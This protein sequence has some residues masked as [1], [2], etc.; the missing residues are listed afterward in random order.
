MEISSDPTYEHQI[1]NLSTY[2]DTC[3]RVCRIMYP[4]HV[5]QNNIGF[6]SFGWPKCYVM[7]MF[8]KMCGENLDQIMPF[9]MSVRLCVMLRLH[10]TFVCL[11]ALCGVLIRRHAGL[12]CRPICPQ[13]V[14]TDMPSGQTV[15]IHSMVYVRNRFCVWPDDS[16]EP[17]HYTV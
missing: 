13:T 8:K 17:R 16:P 6:V 14:L 1:C 9:V 5:C 7:C 2:V 15:R 11:E 12:V 4:G 10:Y 3:S